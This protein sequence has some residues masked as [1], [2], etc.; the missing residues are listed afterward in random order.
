MKKKMNRREFGKLA[1]G[2]ALLA[3]VVGGGELAPMAPP[4]GQETPSALKLTPEQEER[5]QQ[6][7]ERTAR[8]LRALREPAIAYDAEPAFV[9][10][11]RPAAARKK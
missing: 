9:F 8:Q 2:A 10:R 7:R 11:A 3:P 4:A 5:V 6:A 1:G